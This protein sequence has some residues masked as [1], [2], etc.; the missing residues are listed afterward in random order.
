[1]RRLDEFNGANGGENIKKLNV[2]VNNGAEEQLVHNLQ[3]G[4]GMPQPARRPREDPPPGPHD[5]T[6]EFVGMALGQLPTAVPH[7]LQL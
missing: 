5:L 6:G 7:F 2:S 1:M 3:R 4:R